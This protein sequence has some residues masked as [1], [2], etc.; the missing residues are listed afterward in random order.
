MK[1]NNEF[2]EDAL[3]YNISEDEIRILEDFRGHESLDNII[4]ELSLKLPNKKIDSL[5]ISW[6]ISTLISP[7][8]E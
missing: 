6:I 1:I 4:H 8:N 2:I 5:L 7:V 3:Q